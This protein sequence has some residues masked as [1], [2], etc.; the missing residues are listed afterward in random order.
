MKDK[1]MVKL[2]AIICLFAIY[3]VDALT[4][5]I[6]HTVTMALISMIAGMA[7]YEVGINAQKPR[8]RKK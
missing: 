5:Q 3:V 7:G 1:T 2:T 6:D 4:F 8:R